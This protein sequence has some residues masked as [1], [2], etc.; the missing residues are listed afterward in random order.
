M[1]K[2][3]INSFDEFE[4]YVGELLGTSEWQKIT[5][6]QINKFADATLDHQWIHTDPESANKEGPFGTTI[7]HGYLTL[8]ILPF[9]WD[10][11][12]EVNNISMLV[13]YGIEN[14]KFSQAVLVNSE[15]RMHATLKSIK[16]LR[17]IAKSEI[18]VTLE[19]KDYKKPAL[20]ATVI[21][22]YHFKKG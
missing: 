6:E 20:E 22:L 18:N 14:L 5:Q 11:I 19:I 10:Q 17:G 16:D 7:A 21:F 8:S 13:N 15:V 3:V 1:G 12:I 4:K 2:L 9:H